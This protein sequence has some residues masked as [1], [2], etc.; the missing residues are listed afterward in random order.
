MKLGLGRFSNFQ[1]QKSSYYFIM[2]LFYE[3]K[4]PHKARGYINPPFLIDF[5]L[6]FSFL[7]MPWH[8][9]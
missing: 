9:F 2:G 6:K 5:V 8:Y 3:Q 1:F 7:E 4:I